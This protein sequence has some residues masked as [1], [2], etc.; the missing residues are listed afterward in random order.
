MIAVSVSF[1]PL[2]DA[3]VQ[4]LDRRVTSAA[5]D[6]ISRGLDDIAATARANVA[7]LRDP[8]RPSSSPLA[9]SIQ[10]R[11]N[12]DGLGGAVQAGGSQAPYA[13]FI[14]FGTMRSPAQPFLAPALAANAV[15]IRAD[16]ATALNAALG[17]R[18]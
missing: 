17:G 7:A 12:V 6:A 15:R 3:R 8:G 9:E 5:G 4:D 16:I 2:A 10:S 1:K 14:E 18:S 11:M 13:V